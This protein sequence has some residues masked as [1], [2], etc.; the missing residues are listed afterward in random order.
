MCPGSWQCK[1]FRLVDGFRACITGAAS[2]LGFT[3]Q[4]GM[5]G[6]EVCNVLDGG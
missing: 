6:S 1:L 5:P 3:F 4:V 2:G